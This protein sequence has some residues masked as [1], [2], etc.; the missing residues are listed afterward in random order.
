MAKSVHLALAAIAVVAVPALAANKMGAVS[1][2]T[3]KTMHAAMSLHVTPG[4][5]EITVT[6]NMKGELPISS[7]ELAQIPP[8]RRAKMM[9]AM[10]G[11]LG[12]P[13]KMREC[14]TTEKLNNGF[15]IGHDSSTCTQTVVT[16]TANAMEVQQKCSGDTDGTQ[17][18]DVKFLASSPTSVTGTTHV[19]AARGGHS[20]TLDSTLTGQWVSS[21]CGKVKDVE[22]EK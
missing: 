19:I 21:S 17:S 20:M 3:T 12:T 8:E 6:P 14:M 1:T 2:A 18:V 9:A 15:T 16:N 13:H 4:L 7:E 10:R 5:W 11:I 22:V